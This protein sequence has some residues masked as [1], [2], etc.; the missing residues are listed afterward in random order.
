VADNAVSI[1][2]VFESDEP[3]WLPSSANVYE[4]DAVFAPTEM[5]FEY[6][7]AGVN[8]K[9]PAPVTD[10]EHGVNA[11]PVKVAEAGHVTTVV[12]VALFTVNEPLAYEV[13]L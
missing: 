12:D 4:A 2:N 7:A 9:P 11:E 10:T 5:L 1:E 13:G 3:V 6:A 8:D